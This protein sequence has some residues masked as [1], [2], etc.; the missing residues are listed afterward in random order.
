M[1][2]ACIEHNGY[3]TPELNDRL[4]LHFCGYRKI[5]NLESYTGVTA[6]WLDSNGLSAIENLVPHLSLL[7]CL[8]LHQNLIDR[9][10]NLAGLDQL[11]TLNLSANRITTV[12]NLACLPRLQTLNL[13]K[14]AIADA[15]SLAHLHG[16]LSLNN[17]D[18][19]DNLLAGDAG[20]AAAAVA[21]GGGGGGPEEGEGGAGAPS[22]SPSL[23][24]TLRG[25]PKLVTLYLKGNPAVRDTRHYRKVVLAGLPA[26]RYLDDRPV[27]EAERLATDAWAAGGQEAEVQ[28]RRAYEEREREKSRTSMEKFKEW[29]DDVRAR[30]K[31]EL[32]ELNAARRAAGEEEA[33]ELPRKSYV[34]YGRVSTKYQTETM[35][36]ARLS[37]RAEALARAGGYHE[38][39]MMDLGR[40]WWTEDGVLDGDGNVIPRHEDGGDGSEAARA[41]TELDEE[42]E[43]RLVEERVMRGEREDRARERG[44]EVKGGKKKKKEAE[45]EEGEGEEEE[46]EEDNLP[47][48]VIV[49]SPKPTATTR[50]AAAAGEGEE[51]AA[52]PAAA[53]AAPPPSAAELEMQARVEESLRLYKERSGAGAMGAVASPRAALGAEGA[54]VTE[55]SA[56]AAPPAPPLSPAA[57]SF[58]SRLAD[59]R[60]EAA[61]EVVMADAAAAGVPAPAPASS[62]SSPPSSSSWPAPLDAALL[63]FVPQAAFDF[64]KVARALKSAL[65]RGKLDAGGETPQ[66]VADRIDEATC[67]LRYAALT[68][69]AAAEEEAQAGGAAAAANE[70]A[71]APAPAAAPRTRSTSAP[72]FYEVRSG[73]GVGSRAPQVTAAG[74]ASAPPSSAAAAAAPPSPLAPIPTGPVK[75][76]SEFLKGD[77]ALDHFREYVKAPVNLPTLRPGTAAGSG[78]SAAGGGGVGRTFVVSVS[79]FEGG[80]EGGEE[81]QNEAPGG[82]QQARRRVARQADDDEDEKDDE[83]D[84]D[85]E[86]PMTRE[87][88]LASIRS[89]KG[90][91]PVA[92]VAALPTAAAG[93]AAGT[94]DVDGLD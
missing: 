64:E 17:L 90:M 62:P 75:P 22:P 57:P 68:A 81:D 40:Q 77:F 16:C 73:T 10:Q 56:L 72:R 86:A 88:I 21:G 9:I 33:S 76:L 26:L 34:S 52:P 32:D 58:T 49:T 79:S 87:Q 70:A 28:A 44:E 15:S 92:P 29:Q 65:L 3:E 91:P 7:R 61:A 45:G 2:V 59:A 6:L 11:Q 14:N 20:V 55:A 47:G 25:V 39:A 30:R 31:R 85:E 12:E 38:T 66:T 24:S 8:Y 69:A 51:A 48:C 63:R 42:A 89:G 41:S 53:P 54:G 1:P 80:D 82:K 36:L 18:L 71:P 4:Y 46:D 23:V 60:R 50:R 5:E 19:S 83:D 27:F 43:Q 93:G 13:A 37:E 78:S 35:R 67:R 74:G 84:D 94:T